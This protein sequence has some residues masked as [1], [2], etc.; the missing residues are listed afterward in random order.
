MSTNQLETGGIIRAANGKFLPGTKSPKPITSDNAREMLAKRANKAAQ[1]ARQRILREAASIDPDV[2]DIYDAH[3]LMLAKQYT[4]ILD[5]DKPRMTDTRELA[6]LMGTAVPYRLQS[7]GDAGAV[8]SVVIDMADLTCVWLDVMQA[9]NGS[10]NY[11][12]RKHEVDT[13]DGTVTEV[14]HISTEAATSGA[15]AQDTAGEG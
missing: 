14:A 11:S 8:A 13:V 2:H 5:S 1:R 12:Y 7:G 10:D 9:Q 4:T 3:A 15:A 6:E